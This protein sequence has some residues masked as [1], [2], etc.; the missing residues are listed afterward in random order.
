MLPLRF[1]LF[2]LI[3]ADAAFITI[4]PL[5]PSFAYFD[6]DA[7]HAPICCC[8]IRDARYVDALLPRYDY[9]RRC[10]DIAFAAIYLRLL[11]ADAP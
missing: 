3:A 10:A 7:A 5:M 2:Q 1:S 9:F 11:A 6:A 4:T 8:L